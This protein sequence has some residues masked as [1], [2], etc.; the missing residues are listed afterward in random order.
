MRKLLLLL[1]LNG[2]TLSLLAQPVNDECINTIALPNMLQY[3]SAIG[4]FDNEDGT[5]SLSDFPICINEGETSRDVWFSFVAGATDASVQIRG[6]AT[7]NS[8]GG[9]IRTPQFILYSGDCDNLVEEGCISS[10][11]A[12]NAVF[13]IFTNLNVGQTYYLNVSARLG[14]QGSFQLCVEQFNAVPEPSGD[15]NTGVVLCDKSPFTVPFLSGRGAIQEDLESNLLC[16]PANCGGAG[17]LTE[18]NSTWYKW[19]CDDPGTLTFRLDPLGPPLEDLDFLVYELPGGLDDCDNKINLRCML[20]GITAPFDDTDLP[21]LGETGLSDTD[22]DSQEECGCQDGN[23]NFVQSI[24]MVAGRSYALLIMNFTSSGVGFNISFGGTGTFLGPKASFTRDLGQACIGEVV[25]FQDDSESLDP[26]VSQEWDFGQN[27]TPRLASGPGPH[28]IAFT[29]PGNQTI[30]L[31][32]ESS[33]GCLVTDIASDLEVVCC[34]DNF[35]TSGVAST[36][37]CPNDSSGTIDLMA[38]TNIVGIPGLSYTWSTGATSEDVQNLPTGDYTV[39]ISANGICET[40]ETFTIDGPPAFAFDTLIGMPTCN[41]GADGSLTLNVT[42]G[43]PP[44]EFSFENGPFTPVNTIT[45]LPIGT[46]NVRMR[47]DNGCLVEQDIF[48]NE[49]VLELD[50]TAIT[51]S[52]PRCFGESNARIEIVLNNGLPPYRYDFNGGTNYQNNP[53]LDSIPSGVYTVSVIDSNAC[54]GL[55]TFDVMDPPP[56]EPN[57]DADDISC[58][59]QVDGL[60]TTDVIGGRPGYTYSWSNGASTPNIMNLTAGNYTVT[61]TDSGGCPIIVDTFIIE[62]TEIVAVIDQIIDNVC[63]GAADG[64]VVLGATGGTSPYTYSTDGELFQVSDSLTNLP[65]GDYELV[66]MDSEG[67]S[68]S[69]EASISEPAAFIIDPGNSILVN[70][71]FDTTLSAV[72]NYSPVTYS[73]AGDTVQCLNVDCSRVL[74][75]PFN[76]TTFVVTGVNAA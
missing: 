51:L 42:G 6:Q 17:G 11:A 70:L 5:T 3:C 7:N 48:V 45:D 27:A 64:V 53:I 23:N 20:S 58:F 38:S 76:S 49:L 10:S 33:R 69:I 74:V 15:C 56:I 63:F 34:E 16:D 59:G 50:P 36:L 9:T 65:A 75:R 12:D 4:E 46:Y 57:L 61:I 52:E 40:V 73:W 8:G 22:T 43:T 25:T 32:V 28:Q 19:T 71:G 30:R 66:V 44:Y 39:T 26:I 72:A 47:D 54:E 31:R 37:N 68:D 14:R 29:R 1:L 2:L 24:D 18:S 21:C 13:G 60:V 41:E 62:P 67:C 35:T 55:F